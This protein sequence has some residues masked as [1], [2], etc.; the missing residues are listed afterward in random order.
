MVIKTII[1]FLIQV[2]LIGSFSFMFSMF[3]D[4]MNMT[5][6]ENLRDKTP[7]NPLNPQV[8]HLSSSE[9]VHS[10]E[11]SQCRV[12]LRPM[13]GRLL[14]EERTAEMKQSRFNSLDGSTKHGAEGTA[15]FAP[16]N[17]HPTRSGGNKHSAGAHNHTNTFIPTPSG[18]SV[19]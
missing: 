16:D 11:S 15:R 13:R 6:E 12:E 19:I 9:T 18:G 8:H 14:S 1:A 17:H 10:E 4:Q 5:I 3:S 7:L 2:V